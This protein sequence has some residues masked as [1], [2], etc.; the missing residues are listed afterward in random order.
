MHSPPVE[1]PEKYVWSAGKDVEISAAPRSPELRAHN[2]A[3][4]AGGGGDC[5]PASPQLSAPDG[6]TSPVSPVSPISSMG[7]AVTVLC[8]PVRTSSEDTSPP[9]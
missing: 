4:Q 6:P 8:T 5:V 7:G 2:S 3:T 1:L 9:R